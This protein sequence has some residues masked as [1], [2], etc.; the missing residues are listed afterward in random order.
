MGVL[1][2][3]T[4][5]VEVP[6][7]KSCRV[8]IGGHRVLLA[9]SAGHKLHVLTEG[10]SGGSWRA[11][12]DGDTS[13]TFP[14]VEANPA[15]SDGGQQAEAMLDDLDGDRGEPERDVHGLLER[16]TALARLDHRIVGPLLLRVSMPTA[17]VREFAAAI[18]CGKSRASEVLGQ[19]EKAAPHLAGA[20]KPMNGQYAAGQRARRKREQST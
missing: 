17:S 16:L 11:P 9:V 10:Q 19:I 12:T 14:V 3:N 13:L 7:G 18:G 1:N 2:H 6:P 5:I 15:Y 8:E 4:H 20:V